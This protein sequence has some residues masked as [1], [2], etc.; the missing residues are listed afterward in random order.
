MDRHSLSSLFVCTAQYQSGGS[1]VSHTS[2]HPVQVARVNGRKGHLYLWR[3]RFNIDNIMTNANPDWMQIWSSWW[4]VVV[5]VPDV[6]KYNWPDIRFIIA[7]SNRIIAIDSTEMGS[8]L[9]VLNATTLAIPS[10]P[11][12]EFHRHYY[13]Y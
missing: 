3:H 10:V 9:S 2:I 11:S 13:F 5:V 6:T 7:A 8:K 1:P 12:F 4:T